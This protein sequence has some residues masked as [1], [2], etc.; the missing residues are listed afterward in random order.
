ML[1]ALGGSGERWQTLFLL[2]P[3]INMRWRNPLLQQ[4]VGVAGG[5]PDLQ[6]LHQL[7]LVSRTGEL[8]LQSS[9]RQ[10]PSSRFSR[11]EAETP[12]PYHPSVPGEETGFWGLARPRWGRG[13][14]SAHSVLQLK[15]MKELEQEKDFLL[16]GLELVERAREW[17]HQHIQLMQERQRLLGKNKTSAVSLGLRLGVL[18]CLGG[19]GA[20]LW[21]WRI[22]LGFVWT[23]TQPHSNPQP[24][25][26]P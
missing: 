12:C 1:A 5:W 9:I 3:H 18:L 22:G 8:F 6:V 16:Q 2:C 15:H 10:Q 11:R 4:G 24:L 7:W 14:T 20:A 13:D 21:L 17:Y 23:W 25:L 19:P 26:P